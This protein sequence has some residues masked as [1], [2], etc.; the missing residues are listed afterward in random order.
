MSVRPYVTFETDFPM[1]FDGDAPLD[2][3]LATHLSGALRDQGF[4]I[5]ELDWIDYAWDFFC[6]VPHGRIY[7]VL[8]PCDDGPRQWLITTT[9]YRRFF[10]W[11]L[12]RRSVEDDHRGLCQGIHSILSRDSRFRSVRWYTQKEWDKGFG[13]SWSD[14]P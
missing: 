11:L 9:P 10:H 8:G 6:Y 3:S 1:P 12:R 4:H 7:C 2:D 14:E 5:S 13:E